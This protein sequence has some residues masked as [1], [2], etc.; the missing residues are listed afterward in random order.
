MRF[1][2]MSYVRSANAHAP[3]DQRFC[4]SLEYFMTG[5]LLN[6]QHLEFISLLN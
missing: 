5:K 3:S 2:T 4:R 1:T 6:E